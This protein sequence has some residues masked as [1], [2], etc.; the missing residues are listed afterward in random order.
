[1]H[2]RRFSVASANAV[3]C[4]SWL[5]VWSLP[6]ISLAKA[7]SKIL[8]N[9]WCRD[10]MQTLVAWSQH[11]GVARSASHLRPQ[12]GYAVGWLHMLEK[13]H[14]PEKSVCPGCRRCSYVFTVA[15]L[16]VL[17]LV[18]GSI[19][20]GRASALLRGAFCGY[21]SLYWLHVHLLNTMWQLLS[22]PR[23]ALGFRR[24][25]GGVPCLYSYAAWL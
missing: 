9:T 5:R 1:M 3:G 18:R 19:R 16:A 23:H 21:R 6:S 4:L 20:L 2:P 8:A 13:Q 12:L 10:V 11:V 7:S 14:A 17:Q 25:Q 24:R 22:P 15:R